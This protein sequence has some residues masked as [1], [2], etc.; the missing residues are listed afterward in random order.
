MLNAIKFLAF[1]FVC[2]SSLKVMAQIQKGDYLTFDFSKRPI[3]I[4]AGVKLLPFCSHPLKGKNSYLKCVRR[5][6]T[7][8]RVMSKHTSKGEIQFSIYIPAIIPKGIQSE[9]ME[10]HSSSLLP[11]SQDKGGE[12][13]MLFPLQRSRG[14]FW[15]LQPKIAGAEDSPSK[16]ERVAF[17]DIDK[18]KLG[19]DG[20]LTVGKDT[21]I[22][23]AISAREVTGH[24]GCF[25][26][27]K[28]EEMSDTEAKF[29][30]TC[31]EEREFPESSKLLRGLQWLVSGFS[32][33][34]EEV[35]GDVFRETFSGGDFTQKICSPTESLETVIEKFNTSC[36]KPYKDNF[37]D[38]FDKA[39][40]ES[41]QEGVSPEIVLAMMSM[42]P[43]G[44]CDLNR[45][46]RIPPFEIDPKKHQC[47]DEKGKSYTKNSRKV[48]RCLKNPVN[49][50]NTGLGILTSFYKKA[51]DD[52]SLSP[53][54]CEAWVEMSPKERDNWRRGIS[55]LQ[56]GDPQLVEKAL[57]SL[58]NESLIE[59]AGDIET[60]KEHGVPERYLVKKGEEA[61]WEKLRL[62]FLVAS[63]V[64]ADVIEKLATKK[65]PIFAGLRAKK[66]V[67]GS[68]EDVVFTEAILGREIKDNHLSSPGMVELWSQYVRDHKPKACGNS[69]NNNS[70]PKA[71]GPQYKGLPYLVDSEIL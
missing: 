25:V 69:K 18:V 21:V 61:D 44:M 32:D 53:G 10:E 59:W 6:H 7:M 43:K 71:R 55:S 70:T 54:Q 1:F 33:T 68:F 15:L 45:K 39:Y 13:L 67:K 40:C 36:P 34:K 12:G 24:S 4:P 52:S 26:V 63:I 42:N 65:Y 28:Q 35:E 50:L 51:N 48:K 3:K 60:W 58:S 41:C 46:K 20:S 66:F 56:G 64:D 5:L 29:C 22:L 62:L 2:V 8:S 57:K 31:L 23:P 49:H 37:R 27:D 47:R 38:F 17:A 11:Q 30:I 19:A 9:K 14:L 16:D